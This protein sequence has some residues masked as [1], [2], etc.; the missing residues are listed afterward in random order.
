MDYESLTEWPSDQDLVLLCINAQIESNAHWVKGF[1]FSTAIH[2]YKCEIMAIPDTTFDSFHWVG[3]GVPSDW[4]VF[5][6]ETCLE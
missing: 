5:N 1:H 2:T 3:H 4:H 6:Q